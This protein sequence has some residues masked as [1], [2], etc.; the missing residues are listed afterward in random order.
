MQQQK[1]RLDSLPMRLALCWSRLRLP[2]AHRILRSLG[3]WDN[4]LWQGEPP[5]ICRGCYHGYR[6]R[7][8][9][10]DY[11][12]R[13]A[14]FYSGLLD[15]SVDL[16]ILHAL[17]A[18]DTFIDVGANI[19]MMTMLAA[20]AVGPE[21]RIIAFEP[22]P[23]VYERLLWHISENRLAQVR[24]HQLALSDHDAIMQLTVPPTGNTGAATL[25]ALPAR[26]QGRIGATYEVA[27]RVGDEVLA[28][29]SLTDAP[30][31]IKLDVEGHEVAALRGLRDTI[32]K[33]R[34]A[35]LLESNVEMLP[36]NRTSVQ[37][38]FG[39]LVDVG[40]EPYALRIR[41]NRLM[42]RW[43]LQLH[44]MGVHWH[45]ART[46]N[47]LFLRPGEVHAR[48]LGRFFSPAAA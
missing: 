41:W 12:Q 1:S 39:L 9:I 33:H 23:D 27:V 29:E 22:N 40:Y 34:P 35:V 18:G 10:S 8:D 25:G 13:G 14:Y 38:L 21:G 30:L 17:S 24:P 2:R 11:H 36:Q 6:M 45:P 4:R 47:V 42:R 48:R 43:Q 31:F 37:E 3:V 20:H 19:G 5:R 32:R 28:E 44:A 16:C 15:A 7:L 46:E 26:H